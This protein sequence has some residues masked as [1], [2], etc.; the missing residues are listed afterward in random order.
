MKPSEGCDQIRR[1]PTTNITGI[2]H[3]LR[4]ELVERW[5]DSPVF[6]FAYP[7]Y[8]RNVV[9]SPQ[10]PYTRPDSFYRICV[11][12]YYVNGLC[13]WGILNRLRIS[14]VV[15]VFAP[16]QVKP[17]EAVLFAIELQECEIHSTS[18]LLLRGLRHYPDL[19]VSVSI[20]SGPLFA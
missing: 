5:Q 15:T 10:E 9:Q 1:S 16:E 4:A 8:S 19:L 14:P 7:D 3:T 12:S 18:S 13:K 11:H 6:W 20:S 2:P 17:M